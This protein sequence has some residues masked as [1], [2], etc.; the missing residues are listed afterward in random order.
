MEGTE[1]ALCPQFIPHA[2]AKQTEVARS[3][4]KSGA[5]VPGVIATPD[6]LCLLTAFAS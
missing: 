4:R 5:Y 6:A 2:R 1:S 3:A